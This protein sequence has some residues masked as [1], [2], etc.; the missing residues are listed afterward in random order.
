M[1]S[2]LRAAGLPYTTVR[3]ELIRLRLAGER[4]QKAL[5]AEI[6]TVITMHLAYVSAFCIE[7][8]DV[9]SQRLGMLH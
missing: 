3:C 5:H 1:T 7:L 2:K 4:Y 9:L 6:L 8:S